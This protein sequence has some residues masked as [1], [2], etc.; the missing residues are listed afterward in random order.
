MKTY[1]K[2]KTKSSSFNKNPKKRVSPWL[3]QD[4]EKR[5]EHLKGYESKKEIGRFRHNILLTGEK[6]DVCDLFIQL[7]LVFLNFYYLGIKQLVTR[8][9][10]NLYS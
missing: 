9:R 3:T 6:L 7:P 5:R 10:A 2:Y 8:N 1:H 4:V